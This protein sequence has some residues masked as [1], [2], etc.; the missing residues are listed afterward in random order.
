[1]F[2]PITKYMCLNLLDYPKNLILHH[3]IAISPFVLRFKILSNH[4]FVF[5][6]PTVYQEKKITRNLDYMSFG[7]YL[8]LHLLW[9]WPDELFCGK[10]PWPHCVIFL[11]NDLTDY[12]FSHGILMCFVIKSDTA[13]GHYELIA[14]WKRSIVQ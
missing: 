3:T 6:E 11:I 12:A 7:E 4:L 1:M 9:H 13:P 8:E 2:E 14:S 5:P 10:I